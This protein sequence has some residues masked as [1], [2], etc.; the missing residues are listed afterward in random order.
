MTSL[1]EAGIEHKKFKETLVATVHLTLKEREALPA[2]FAK[3]TAA[4]PKAIIAG[5]PFCIIQFVTS[6]QDGFD[7]EVG[8]PVTQAIQQGDIKSR[9]IPA[10]DVLSLVHSGPVDK[11]RESYRNLHSC[12]AELGLIS[13]EFAQEVYLDFAD[14]QNS[15]VE[16]QF[17][18]HDWNRLFSENLERVLGSETKQA[19]VQGIDNLNVESMLNER[20]ERL[21]GTMEALE[22]Q[23]SESQKYDILSSCAHIFPQSQ[24]AKLKTIY[25]RSKAQTGNLLKAVDAV[26]A[27]MDEDPGWGGETFRE[28]RI[29]YA[30]KNPRDPQAYAQAKDQ[31]ER[32]RAYCFCPLVRKHLDQGMSPTFCYCG[33]GWYRQ[34]WEGALGEPLRI[35]IVKS[36]LKGDDR[37][38]FAIHLPDP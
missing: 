7:A 19:I 38:Q 15:K 35:Q 23:A 21:K 27:F 20:L 17:V 4:L 14:L 6:I 37:C 33:S 8:F 30:S 3:L 26:I 18:L 25:E 11:I 29:I 5:L 9:L 34:Q 36:I 10:I 28:G 1:E 31:A 2:I 12:A 16:V 32:G 22:S 24:I 13:D